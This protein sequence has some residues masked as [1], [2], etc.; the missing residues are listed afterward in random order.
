M[1]ALD[2]LLDLPRMAKED[3]ELLAELRNR[4][5]VLSK[6]VP[7]SG[8]DDDE[9][10]NLEDQNRALLLNLKDQNRAIFFKDARVKAGVDALILSTDPWFLRLFL[11]LYEGFARQLSEEDQISLQQVFDGMEIFLAVLQEKSAI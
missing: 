3:P 2:G 9:L 6:A 5:E 7:L 11:K 8:D 10:H 4:A 1:L